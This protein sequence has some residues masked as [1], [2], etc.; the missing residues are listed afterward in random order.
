MTFVMFLYDYYDYY[1]Y[2]KIMIV[3]INRKM[4]KTVGIKW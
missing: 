1:D 2:L 4:L 3:T